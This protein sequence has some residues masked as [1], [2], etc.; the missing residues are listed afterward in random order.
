[1][2]VPV[3]CTLIVGRLDRVQEYYSLLVFCGLLF[4]LAC[5]FWNTN[6]IFVPSLFFVPL[7]MS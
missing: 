4:F 7:A 1:M 3:S 6:V 2:G 5:F